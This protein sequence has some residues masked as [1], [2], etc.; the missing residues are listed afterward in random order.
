MT[1]L[2]ATLTQFR[3]ELEGAIARDLG[4][5]RRRARTLRPLTA[6]AAVALGGGVAA[7]VLLVGGGPSIV[8][9]AE[10]ALTSPS[11]Q[12]LHMVM[13]G[14]STM[15]DGR[16]VSWQDE[17]WLVSG[18]VAPRR[19]V[20]TSVDGHRFE[21]AMTDD[22]LAEFYDTASNTIYAARVVIDP[23]DKPDL[24]RRTLSPQ[25]RVKL[26]LAG[27]KLEDDGHVTVDGRDA[28]RLV[29][30]DGDVTYL[31]DPDTYVPIELHAT[32]NGGEIDLRFPVYEQLPA[33]A[34]SGALFSLQ[35]QHPGA[36]VKI[37]KLA[38]EA[39]W[40][41]VAPRKP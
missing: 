17:E 36:V 31:V 41:E 23:A 20:Q 4:R 3:T 1:N 19:A 5:H 25:E 18:S 38:Y 22:G 8:E 14:R 24:D 28:T 30:A 6:T 7:A 9:R 13:V 11:G 37:D 40:S 34:V 10:A 39:H 32:R 35:A 21:T 33:P 16:V 29:T 15:A 2:P 12:A 27:G 26:L